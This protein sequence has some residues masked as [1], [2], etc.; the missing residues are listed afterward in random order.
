MSDHRDAAVRDYSVNA[1]FQDTRD[2]FGVGDELSVVV[3]WLEEM[4]RM[5]LLKTAAANFLTWN[6]GGNSEDGN[7]A[8]ATCS[9]RYFPRL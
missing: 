4:V 1:D 7:T 5:S 3:T 9:R 8:A 6:L 2:L